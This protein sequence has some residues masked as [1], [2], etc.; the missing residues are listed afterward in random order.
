M[1]ISDL[2]C[3]ITLWKGNYKLCRFWSNLLCLHEEEKLRLDGND[4]YDK[5][6]IIWGDKTITYTAGNP[7]PT[8]RP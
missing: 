3:M 6:V 5:A 4:R 7:I 2:D 8:I 1:A